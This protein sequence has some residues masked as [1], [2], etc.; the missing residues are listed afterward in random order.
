MTA[1]EKPSGQGSSE[2]GSV[3]Y[4]S[5]QYPTGSPIVS[6]FPDG[7]SLKTTG[8]LIWEYGRSNL[9]RDPHQCR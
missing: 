2:A 8:L 4:P 6:L 5:A 3:V 1:Q 9:H 7:K